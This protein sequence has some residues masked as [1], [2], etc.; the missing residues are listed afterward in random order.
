MASNLVLLSVLA[1]AGDVESA[2]NAAANEVSAA[3]ASFIRGDSRA[4]FDDTAAALAARK[5]PKAAEALS[6]LRG[7]AS[8]AAEVIAAGAIAGRWPEGKA[9]RVKGGRGHEKEAAAFIEAEAARIGAAFIASCDAAAEARKAAAKAARDAAKAEKAK[10]EAA[11]TMKAA[12]EGAA[13]A[14][15]APAPA[16]AAAA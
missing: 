9:P 7:A 4:T 13:P 8:A 6:A 11:A 15:A 2:R 5:G 3:A 1:F 12:A 14:E 10:A 16:E